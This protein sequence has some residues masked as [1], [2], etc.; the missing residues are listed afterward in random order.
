MNIKRHV[1]VAL[2]LI[3]ALSITACSGSGGRPISNS[4]VTA[5][6]ATPS[7]DKHV[8]P[9]DPECT[10]NKCEGG[11][12]CK[13]GTDKENPPL[14]YE[15]VIKTELRLSVHKEAIVKYYK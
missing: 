1:T 2:L 12:R 8:C 13:C 3:L 11:D 10:N 15:I 9:C 7:S 14:T 5:P 4:P 6:D